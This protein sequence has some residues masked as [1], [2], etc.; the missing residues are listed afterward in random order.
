MFDAD[1]GRSVM[2]V[3]SRRNKVAAGN[4]WSWMSK[5]VANVVT[6]TVRAHHVEMRWIQGFSMKPDA[7]PDDTAMAQLI[8]VNTAVQQSLIKNLVEAPVAR[9]QPGVQP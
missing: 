3:P 8:N 6:R 5:R 2:A 1:A 4:A 9:R 7:P